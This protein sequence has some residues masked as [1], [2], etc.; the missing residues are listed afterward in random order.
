MVRRA[1]TIAKGYRRDQGATQSRW[2]GSPGKGTAAGSGNSPGFVPNTTVCKKFCTTSTVDFQC[3]NRGLR[4]VRCGRSPQV[5]IAAKGS[6]VPTH[7]KQEIAH[8]SSLQGYTYRN[9]N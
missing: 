5:R 7:R 8:Q 3:L 6:G 1:G 4:G 9:L 2:F